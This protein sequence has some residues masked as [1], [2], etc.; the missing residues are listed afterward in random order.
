MTGQSDREPVLPRDGATASSARERSP[1][2]RRDRLDRLLVTRGLVATR[3]RAT[4]LIMTGAVQVDGKRVTKPGT[5]VDRESR[6][7]VTASQE[8]VSRGGIKLEAAFDSFDIRITGAVALDV[9]ASTGGFT[10]VLLRRG[11]QRVYAIDVGYGQLA[12]ELRQDERVIVMERTNIRHVATLPEPIDLASIDVSFI[13]LHH[14]LPVVAM[15]LTHEGDVVTLIKPQFEAGRKLV[16]KGGVVRDPAV[17]R[18][19]LREVLSDAESSG[20]TVVA[21][22]P[23][24]ITGPAGNREFLAHL[25][26]RQATTESRV[27][28]LVE[29][30]LSAEETRS[31]LGGGSSP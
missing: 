24:P 10:D 30:A 20:W 12:W 21:L 22:T 28:E 29:A 2:T 27:G 26:R 9:G 31:L 5:A 14:V 25:R 3:H 8:Y 19:V 23:S 15:L 17:H 16:G 7:E 11:A 4:G 1:A 18:D 6:I 13:S